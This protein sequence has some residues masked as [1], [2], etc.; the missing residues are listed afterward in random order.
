MAGK[1]KPMSQIKQLLLQH[2]QGTGVKTI[3]RNLGISKNTVKSYLS[4]LPAMKMSIDEMLSL[5]DP[6]LEAMPEILPTKMNVL[7]TLNL[8]S[9]ILRRNWTGLALTERSFGKNTRWIFHRDTN[10]LSFATILSSS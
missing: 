9:T 8:I 7:S 5:E 1:P 3:A 4:K 6:E 2:K 10:T